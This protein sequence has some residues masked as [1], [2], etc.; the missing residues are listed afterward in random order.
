VPGIFF[1]VILERSERIHYFYLVM[2]ATVPGI[3]L[4]SSWSVAIGSIIFYLVMPASEFFDH[5]EL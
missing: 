1:A 2:P 5:L 4:L 3:F